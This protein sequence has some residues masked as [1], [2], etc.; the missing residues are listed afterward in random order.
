MS[1]E[2]GVPASNLD[3]A[4]RRP[5]AIGR[6]VPR[7][8]GEAPARSGLGARSIAATRG[9]SI[10]PAANGRHDDALPAN[11]FLRDL[12]REKR[13]AE[14]SKAPLSLVL[15]RLDENANEIHAHMERLL[16]LLHGAKR[17]TDIL[18]H[19]GDDLIGVL[20][21]DTD[22]RGT[23]GFMRKIEGQCGSMPLVAVASTY[24]DNLFESLAAGGQTQPAFK[25]F[26]V[27]ETTVASGK[28]YTLK[29][30]LDIVVSI[31]AIVLLAPL[32]LA[33]AA[34]I[35][36]TSRGPV[37]F[38]QKRLGQ[39]GVPFTFY[40]FRSMV[41]NVDD[42]IHREYV[43][44]LINGQTVQD[45]AG[46]EAPSYKMKKDPRVTA[47]GRFI[48]KTS[49]DELP[50]LFN[51]LKGDMSLVGPRPPIPYEATHY[52]PWH[53]RRVMSIKPGITGIWQVEGRS[54]V[55]FNEM[56]RMDLRYMRDCSIGLDF[57]ILFKTVFVV[58]RCD[59]AA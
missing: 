45:A 47:V 59:G 50:Q 13:R 26:V 10:A 31:L 28:T 14:R 37:I 19:V 29:R 18:G 3:L 52:Q 24:P 32:M 16:E 21:P 48:R 17:E 43:A 11:Q 1:I 46:G 20:C 49:I 25:P 30:S 7:H 39:G 4:G 8:D 51:V 36:F 27:S 53:L 34:A 23:K 57:R 40:K 44:N 42:A 5:V 9:P 56:V 22:E 38:K 35:E 58:L 6:N 2:I 12:H 55:G 41:T 15:Y 54:R 33:I